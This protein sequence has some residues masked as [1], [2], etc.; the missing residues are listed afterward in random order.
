MRPMSSLNV[1]L[2]ALVLGCVAGNPSPSPDAELGGPRPP[3]DIVVPLRRYFRELMTVLVRA[4]ADTLTMLLDTGG[5][6]TLITPDVA[7]RRGCQPYGRDVGHRMS[8][9]AVVFRRCDAIDLDLGGWRRP[10]AP[11]AVFDVNALLPPQLPR[12]DGVLA[13]DT[14]RDQVVTF[15]WPGRRLRIH[16]GRDGLPPRSE[17]LVPY[18]AA[19]GETGGTLTVL[20]PVEGRRGPLWFLLDSGN[21]RGTLVADWVIEDSLLTRSPDSTTTVR[22]GSR[23][24]WRTVLVPAELI[25]DGALGTTFFASGPLT[26]DLRRR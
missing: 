16:G 10:L 26:L 5:G 1:L 12:L 4:D 8:G 3:S 2:C 9:E 22:I 7:R 19:T 23:A 17:A 14:F 24:P 13:L 11:V 15:D 25:L 21:L 6:A 18:R 20:V